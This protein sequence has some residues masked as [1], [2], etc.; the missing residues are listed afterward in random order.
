M[1]H[2]SAFESVS[3]TPGGAMDESLLGGASSSGGGGSESAAFDSLFDGDGQYSIDNQ[4]SP[5]AFGDGANNFSLGQCLQCAVG[6]FTDVLHVC[7]M[8]ANFTCCFA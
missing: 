1:L 5:Q 7:V 3:A 2:D 8:H 6:E 4:L